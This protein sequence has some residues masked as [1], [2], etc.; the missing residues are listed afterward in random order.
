MEIKNFATRC[1]VRTYI[2]KR[3]RERLSLSPAYT[4]PKL[5]TR[6]KQVSEILFFLRGEKREREST[7]K[8]AEEMAGAARLGATIRRLLP[9]VTELRRT[10]HAHP[11]VSEGERATVRRIRDFLVG[12][13]REGVEGLTVLAE[14]VGG[15]HGMVVEVR[16][17]RAPA[18]QVRGGGDIGDGCETVAIRADMDALPLTELAG[19]PGAPA[20]ISTTPGAHHACG[21]DGHASL[22]AGALLALAEHRTTFSGRVLGIFQPAEENGVGAAQMIRGAERLD[23]SPLSRESITRGVYGLHNIPGSAL[24]EVSMTRCGTASRASCGLRIDVQGR[25]SHASQPHLGL[26]ALPVLSRLALELKDLPDQLV[27][28]GQ[29]E[30]QIAD[31]ILAVP[32]HMSFGAAGDY[33]VLPAN[34]ALCVT[35]RADTSKDLAA[36]VRSVESRVLEL[37]AEEEATLGE[38]QGFDIRFAHVEKFPSVEND[39]ACT[40]IV[41]RAV[42]LLSAEPAADAR[43]ESPGCALSLAWRDRPFPW[44]EDFGHFKSSYGA[45]SGAVL[46]GLGAGIEHPP[47]HSETYDFPDALLEPGMALWCKV[48][49][50]A[51]E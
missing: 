18:R 2:C 12:R 11:E 17:A 47:L 39:S 50:C 25:A 45:G 7:H 16:G 33:G 15:G 10:L 19:Y 1:A 14:G 42:G 38:S 35:L 24:G 20:H 49:T 8:I 6:E 34:G 51:L 32:V 48:A 29:V 27:T 13:S 3:E 30:T 26:S 23:G 41:A 31:P 44:S 40:D 4:Y 46:L 9:Q 5:Y 28:S 43:G 22:L 21:H 36:A 37:A